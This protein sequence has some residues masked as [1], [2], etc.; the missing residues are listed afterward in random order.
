MKNGTCDL[1]QL[2]RAIARNDVQ[3]VVLEAD[4]TGVGVLI[5]DKRGCTS[6][7]ISVNQ[8]TPRRY[9]DPVRAMKLLD[10]LGIHEA[11]FVLSGRNTKQDI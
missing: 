11:K 7:L 5:E 6:T 1:R 2:R 8:Q 3:G 4:D 10:K 9:M